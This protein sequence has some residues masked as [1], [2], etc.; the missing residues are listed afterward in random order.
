MGITCVVD[1]KGAEISVINK[2][3]HSLAH[4]HSTLHIGTDKIQNGDMLLPAY[5]DFPG[6]WRLSVL[7]FVGKTKRASYVV[8][9]SAGRIFLR[10]NGMYNK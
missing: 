2:Q 6:K 3:I 8:R 9:I 10:S 5:M 1:C 7:S 4:I